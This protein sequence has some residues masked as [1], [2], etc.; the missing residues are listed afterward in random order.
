MRHPSAKTPEGTREAARI[1]LGLLRRLLRWLRPYRLTVLWALLLATISSVLHL[2]GPLLTAAAIDLLFVNAPGS[3]PAAAAREV[4]LALGLPTSGFG[5]LLSLAGAFLL[6]QIGAFTAGSAQSYLMSLTGQY[7]MRDLRAAAFRTLQ[8]LPV[9]W[10]DHQPVGNLISRVINDVETLNQVFSSLLV[11]VLSDLLRLVA[12]VVVLFSLS[13]FLALA[14]FIVLPFIAMLSAWFRSRARGAFR[15]VRSLLADMSARLQEVLSGISAVHLARGEERFADELTAR[16]LEYTRWSVTA[17]LYHSL[18]FPLVELATAVGIALVLGL[19]AG[20]VSRGVVSIGVLVAFVQLANRFY[21]PIASLADNYATLQSSLAAG[22][23]VLA[24]LDTEPPPGPPPLRP[25]P[26]RTGLARLEHVSFAY[27]GEDWVLQDLNLELRPGTVTALV[28]ATGAGKSTIAQLLLGFYAPQRGAVL[29]DGVETSHWNQH[30]LRSRFAVVMQE[31]TVFPGSALDNILLDDP[32]IIPEKAME[33]ARRVGLED[34]VSTLPGG[35][36]T[37]L[38]EGGRTLSL[39]EQ[40]L[41]AFARA[42]ARDPEFL[43]LDEATASIDAAT[44][45]RIQRALNEVLQGRTALII[46]HRLHTVQRAHLTAVL[47]QGRIVERGTHAELIRRGGSYAA[48]VRLQQLAA[49]E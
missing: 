25:A 21:R 37:V 44:E 49:E 30:Q 41:V 26:E 27:Q 16:N 19:G 5:A 8:R 1:D 10:F 33:A 45:A 13:P 20:L 22:E 48:L 29:V 35:W 36:E 18:F 43:I 2:A 28:G 9:S 12:I 40:Q 46:A 31:V 47:H 6:F 17:H 23:R 32:S 38:G 3:R 11:S 42:L 4:L 7:V 15:R 24:L 39:G 14:T 34:V